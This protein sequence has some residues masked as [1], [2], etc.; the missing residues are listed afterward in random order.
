M[1]R[2]PTHRENPPTP[3]ASLWSQESD[4]EAEG[5]TR[6]HDEDDDLS[7]AS[8]GR[9]DY[10]DHVHEEAGEAPAPARSS[11]ADHLERTRRHPVIL[12]GVGASGK[13]TM[14]MS[15][16]QALNRSGEVNIYLGDPILPKDHPEAE[17]AHEQAITFFERDAQSFA[18]GEMVKGTRAER[19]Y[20]IPVDV[21]RRRDGRI[22]RLALLEGQGEWYRPVRRGRGSMFP[23]FKEDIAE[24]ME[25][26]GE[27]LS[28]IWAAPYSIGSGKID[29]EDSDLGLVGAINAYKK[30]RS[31][32]QQDFHLYLLTKWDCFAEPLADKA[33]FSVVTAEMVEEQIQDRYPNSWPN[34]AGLALKTTG[35]RFF[36]Q[37]AAGHIVG[38]RV[39]IPPQRHRA[40]FDRYPRTIWNWLYGNATQTEVA[41]D[42]KLREVL[43][44]DVLPRPP[45]RL[46]AWEWISNFLFSR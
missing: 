46:S 20:F 43:F 1:A 21:E 25:Y 5:P 41:A 2:R 12:F 7:T 17:D 39:R 32:I 36:M 3:R 15:L 38:D 10:E 40:A 37:Y 26:Y 8:P 45:R 13:T 44:P 35:R 27:S 28:V 30:H 6:D 24:I 29:T 22:V 19:P 14:L 9:G 18:L 31:S 4:D 34:F 42:E 16:I 11:L 23:A 33:N